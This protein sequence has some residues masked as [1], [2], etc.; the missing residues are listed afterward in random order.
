MLQDRDTGHTAA[1]M[2]AVRGNRQALGMLLRHCPHAARS[3]DKD[4]CRALHLAIAARHTACVQ[5]ILDCD[6]PSAALSARDGQ[7]ALHV[8]AAARALSTMMV[9]APA[10][11]NGTA[12][13]SERPTRSLVTLLL[14]DSLGLGLSIN[15]P[16]AFGQTPLAY[17]MGSESKGCVEACL[18][19]GADVARA[20]VDG[21][22]MPLHWAAQRGHNDIL[23][24]MIARGADPTVFF[25]DGC[26]VLHWAVKGNLEDFVSML[27][28]LP[29]VDVNV[30]DLERR[31]TPL[32]DA[33]E[34]GH[35]RLVPLL[36]EAGI[37]LHIPG[38]GV[39]GRGKGER[40]GC[41]YA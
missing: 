28:K 36:L 39:V 22:S 7:T 27:L 10:T 34:A 37:R 26:S 16:D 3:L 41:H 11:D 24:L 32:H 6:L 4:G 14:D 15:Q 38:R 30:M 33:A 18:E 40:P 21:Y 23:R 29:R 31:G 5:T 1:H 25:A 8:A 9:A 19:N 20:S 17:A 35:A 13:G 12:Q 2:A